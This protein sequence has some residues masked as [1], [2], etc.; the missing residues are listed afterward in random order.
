MH[1]HTHTERHTRTQTYHVGNAITPRST[2]GR[3]AVP[4]ASQSSKGLKPHSP[5]SPTQQS[6]KF[7]AYHKQLAVKLEGHRIESLEFRQPESPLKDISLVFLLERG[8][9]V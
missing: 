5:M 2:A 9:R 8:F 7:E 1:T 4:T 6:R 3:D